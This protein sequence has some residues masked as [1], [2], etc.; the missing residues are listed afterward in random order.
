MSRCFVLLAAVAVL[1]VVAVLPAQAGSG[2]A[3][4]RY[5]VV[6]KGAVDPQAVADLHATRYAANVDHVWGQ[7]LHGYA[8]VIP[9]DRV[10]EVRA[11]SNVSYVVAD[12][13][14]DPS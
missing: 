6:L 9:N 10:A 4:D 8:A 11:D 3:A 2:S 7:A 14:D 5:I 12:G 1:T 13:I